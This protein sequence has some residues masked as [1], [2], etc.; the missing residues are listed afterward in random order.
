MIRIIVQAA[1]LSAAIMAAGNAD[2]RIIPTPK[3]IEPLEGSVG[4]QGGQIEIVLGPAQADSNPKMKL[5][6][7]YLRNALGPRRGQSDGPRAT[8]HLWDWSADSSPP[9]TVNILDRQVLSDP[10]HFYQSYIILTPDNSN[11][12]AI[13]SSDQGVLFAVMS[14]IQAIEANAQRIPAL[15][16]RD[17]PD[18]EFREAADWLLNGEV[19]RWSIDRGQGIEAVRTLAK[20]KIDLALRF[21]VNMILIDGFGWGLDQRRFAGYGELMRDLNRYARARGIH[22]MY[23]GYGASYGIA[24]Q[25]GP[26][27][28]EGAYLG[29]IFK[30]RE[31]YPDGPVYQCMGFDRG[32]KT[33][34]PSVLGS[35]RSNKMLN[36]LK[37]A[38]LQKFVET[39][40][41]GALYIHHEDFGN[42]RDT[43][44]LWNKRCARCR[45]RWP[46][47]TLSAPDGGAGGLA[48]GY[49]ALVRGIQ[50]VKNSRSGYDAA[51]DCQIVIIS[52][53]Y[54]PDS[55]S[56]EDWSKT[57]SLWQN[58]GRGLPKSSNVQI[59]FREVFPQR[60]GGGRW[61]EAFNTAM[62]AAKL[63]FGMFM[64][65]A[66]GTDDWVSDYPLSGVPSM[67]ML[68][69]GAKTI[70][71]GTGDLY[72]EPMQII[73]A[74]YSW[75]VRSTGFFSDPIENAGAIAIWRRY[76][77]AE[78]EPVA[79]FGTGKLYDQACNLLY[80]PH[81]GPLVAAFYRISAD[82]PDRFLDDANRAVASGYVPMRW[83]RLYA[84][85]SH[86]RDLA[87]DSKTWGA[88]ITNERYLQVMERMHLERSE[89]HRRL[90]RRWRIGSELNR[91]ATE[92]LTKALAANPRPESVD[93]LKFFASILR[94]YQPL[95]DALSE[96]HAGL[97][98]HFGQQDRRR[99]TDLIK[100]A[101]AKAEEART[102]AA[103]AF[104]DVTDPVGGDVGAVRRYSDEL[105][106][107]IMN[108][109]KTI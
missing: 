13:G 81:A 41:P 92:Q 50:S 1:V 20:K 91:K 67:N 65:F 85:P 82:L 80:G 30:N 8:V 105:V 60:Y 74:E 45:K 55:P 43:E 79:L 31:Y 35:C 87:L 34:D 4:E 70:Y 57:L 33:V 104:P 3:Y 103:K 46:N 99:A 61:T 32:K 69:R 28:E 11:V 62:K 27:Y 14:L 15:Y 93:D 39:V 68:F 97:E 56:S 9:V 48:A 24:Y 12:W 95:M 2:V 86:W 53:V 44:R 72:R 89:L 47:N 66:G 96:Y 63:P 73:A 102:S 76:V 84:L 17:Y 23:G 58:I 83:N 21:K 22:L 49:A 16:V 54:V 29:E 77:F 88:Q 10:D 40:E 75:N 5:A 6:A 42:Y 101:L 108:I 36:K 98:L 59:G 64:Y 7:D 109:Q 90:M 107:A 71:N 38:E 94:V 51:R 25:T 19:N 26:I 52:P 106:K 18:F 100:S 78:N 37:A